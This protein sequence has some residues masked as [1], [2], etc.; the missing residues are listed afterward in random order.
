MEWYVQI[1][2]EE[3]LCNGMRSVVQIAYS[4]IIQAINLATVVIA[5][6]CMDPSRLHGKVIL[7]FSFLQLNIGRHDEENTQ[8]TKE[9]E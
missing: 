5:R 1:E 3:G 4:L 7:F 6:H 9:R 8:A 2:R